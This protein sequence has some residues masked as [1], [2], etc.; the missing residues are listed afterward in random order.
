MF[1]QLAPLRRIPSHTLSEQGNMSYRAGD[2]L[3]F[4]TALAAK[5]SF[6]AAASECSVTQPT[7]SN[8]GCRRLPSFTASAP[9]TFLGFCACAKGVPY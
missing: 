2:R 3:R 5:R 1:D 7:L 6:T 4:V 8:P 9:Q